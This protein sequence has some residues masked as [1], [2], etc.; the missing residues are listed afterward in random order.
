MESFEQQARLGVI[1]VDDAPALERALFAS[2]ID[3]PTL[4]EVAFTRASAAG[5]DG[6]GDL[7]VGPDDRWELGV[8]R[9]GTPARVVTRRTERV[10]GAW[11]ARVRERVAG[12]PF[13]SGVVRDDGAAEDPTRTATFEVA[14]AREQSGRPL[15]S[16]LHWSELDPG[17]ERRVVMT[18]QQTVLDGRGRF[19]GVVRVGLLTDQIDRVT[20]VHVDEADAGRSTPRVPLRRAGSTPRA[21]RRPRPARPLRRRPS[22]RAERPRRPR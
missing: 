3:G 17:P 18:V 21:P 6:R 22:L 19:A 15:W 9:T 4:S 14:A 10:S 7:I 5:Y 1:D 2:L 13:T 8:Y 11:I 16:D 20:R 12:E